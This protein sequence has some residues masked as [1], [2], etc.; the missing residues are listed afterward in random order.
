[1][2]ELGLGHLSA[3]ISAEGEGFDFTDSDTWTNLQAD[4]TRLEYQ[5]HSYDRITAEAVLETG[6]YNL[7]IVSY[8]PLADLEFSAAGNIE[9]GLYDIDAKADIANIDLKE[10]GFSEDINGGN[11]VISVSGTA[12]PEAWLYDLKLDVSNFDWNLQD[13]Y[14]HLPQAVAAEF[15]ADEQQTFLCLKSLDIDADFKSPTRL[16]ALASSLSTVMDSTNMMI[17]NRRLDVEMLQRNLPQFTLDMN[18]SGKGQLQ[19]FLNQANLSMDTISLQL[20]NAEKMTAGGLLYNLKVGDVAIDTLNMSMNQR[21]KLLNYRVHM[22]N[23]PGTLDDFARVDLSG[24]L[25]GNRASLSIKQQ[26]IKGKIGYKLGATTAFMEDNVEAHFTPLDAT[27]AYMPWTF[28]DDNFV[29]YTM[30]NNTIHALLYATSNESKIEMKS[31]PDENGDNAVCIKLDNIFIEDFLKLSMTAPPVKGT[32]NSDIDLVYKG[33]AVTGSGYINTEKLTYDRMLLGDFD[34][35]FDADLDFEGNTKASISLLM[36]KHKVLTGR[37]VIDNDTVS[38]KP[39][40]FDLDVTSFPLKLLNPFVGDDAAKFEG[41]VAGKL[42]M[43]GS[44]IK[45]ILNGHLKCSR[46]AADVKMI[47]TKLELDSVPITVKN[48]VLDF[49]NFSITAANKNPLKMSGTVDA[50]NLGDIL[51]DVGL[52]ADNMQL[53]GNDKRSGS[54]IYGKLFYNLNATAKGSLKYLQMNANMTILSATDVFYNLDFAE[55]QTIQSTGADVVKFVNLRDTAKN[56]GVD[57]VNNSMN[58]KIGATLTIQKGARVTVNLSGN[59]TDRV[60]LNPSGTL[61]YAQNV[62]GDMRLNGQLNT[63]QGM[64]N[65]SI[66]AIGAKHFELDPASY[67]LWNGN[68]MNPILHI[69]A[70]DRV[71]ANVSTSGQASRTVTFDVALSVGGTL[72]APK[73][74]FDL[75]TQDDMS[76]Q[77][78]LQSMSADQRSNQAMNLMLYG[79]YTGAGTKTDMGINGEGMLYS[80]LE[81]KLNSWM[82]NNVRGVDISFGIDQYNTNNDGQQG[83]AMSYSY[84]VSKSLFNNRFKIVVGG[85]Y[86][87]DSSADEN[88]AQNLISDVSFEYTFKQTNSLSIVGKLFRHTGFESILEGQI[89]EMGVG[90]V[91]R[92]KLSNLKQLFRFRNR[93][94]R[95]VDE[96]E[97]DTI[98]GIHTNRFPTA[99]VNAPKADTTSNEEELYY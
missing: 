22:G 39:V 23:R 48:S 10:L 18:V 95:S 79:A 50:R 91:M 7:N 20:D 43:T 51:I 19:R 87:T 46:A 1:M 9:N 92:R 71:K 42:V 14:I 33:N 11:G 25:G 65:Y 99:P 38:K 16:K 36:N 85:N 60:V 2:P 61:T 76:I 89:S 80:F 49:N 21:N 94:R 30:A 37:A 26:D 88:F 72:S 78:E 34:F 24:Y 58:M 70:V 90:V 53:V 31:E 57:S 56:A 93:R 17:E 77:N 55:Q 12:N 97:S 3:S 44:F 64:A 96:D 35:N 47:G 66:P 69:D 32:I 4:V 84:Q 27:I 8:D 63:G 74:L 52:R 6:A 75:S 13:Q 73:V 98:P 62:M 67:V 83:S 86:S 81:S 59:G 82:A 54:D 28:N 41:D 40:E 68:P 45:P 15:V 5:G 29:Q